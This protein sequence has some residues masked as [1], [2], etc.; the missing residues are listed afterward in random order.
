MSTFFGKPKLKREH[1]NHIKVPEGSASRGEK[2]KPSFKKI[3][4]LGSRTK[5]A[6]EEANPVK[7]MKGQG[8]QHASSVP[9]KIPNRR[10][11]L[12]GSPEEA[13]K[14][15]E[16]WSRDV[17]KQK[18]EEESDFEEEEV[19]PRQLPTVAHATTTGSHSELFRHI[20]NSDYD[21]MSEDRDDQ[22]RQAHESTVKDGKNECVSKKKKKKP[23]SSSAAAARSHS[24]LF[25]HI[26]DSDYEI[27][28]E[29]GEIG[30]TDSH[31]AG[32]GPISDSNQEHRIRGDDAQHGDIQGGERDFYETYRL[33]HQ[34]ANEQRGNEP[35]ST[36]P[37]PPNGK[38]KAEDKGKP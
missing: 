15:G 12:G 8:Q 37:L 38:K 9:P 7:G 20:I 28:P 24:E 22:S 35:E 6:D 33:F 2:F 1:A 21:P 5:V 31:S 34:D 13:H 27:D 36:T 26:I 14:I 10:N 30:A 17:A 18:I 19:K 16:R 29:D 4:R 25:R 3:I 23:R 11:W 32:S